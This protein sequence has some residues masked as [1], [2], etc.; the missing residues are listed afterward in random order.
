M[1]ILVHIKSTYVIVLKTKY[2]EKCFRMSLVGERF[3]FITPKISP[4]KEVT[5]FKDSDIFKYS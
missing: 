5:K 4:D 1:C 3:T 2:V